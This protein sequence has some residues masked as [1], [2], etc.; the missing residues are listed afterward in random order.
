MSDSLP[1]LNALKA[2]EAAARLGSVTAAAQELSVTHGAVSRQIRALEAHLNTALFERAGRGLV[3]TRHGRQLQSG[4]SE[5]FTGLRASCRALSRDIEDAPFTLACPGSLLARWLIPRLDRLHRELP[6]LRLNV[7]ASEG[8]P[9]PRRSDISAALAFIAPPWPSDMQVIEITAETIGV[10]AAPDIAARLT[11]RPFEA[12]FEE[13]MLETTSRLQAWPQWARACGLDEQALAAAR[14]S[15]QR[16]EHLYYLLEAAL[17][18]LGVAIAPRLVIEG[19]LQS[20]RLVAPWGFV[21]TDAR[22]CLLLAR[23]TPRQGGDQLATWL[24][25]ELTTPA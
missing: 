9:D 20:G 11:G 25:D 22:L 17:V 23:G 5:A 7:L 10:V 16:F 12:L 19:D 14:E 4:V 18:G 24:R 3:L 1:P 13:T 15:S 8:D 21:D 6:A 2:F